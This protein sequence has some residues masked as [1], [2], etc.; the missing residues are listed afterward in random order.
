MKKTDNFF[1]IHNFN[2]VPEVLLSYCESYLIVDASTDKNTENQLKEKGLT[3]I[4]ADNTGHNITTYFEYFAE[5]YERLPEVICLC[6]GN[7]L[8][9][10]LSEEY[11]RRV[12]DNKYFTYLYEDKDS[13]EKFSKIPDADIGNKK[14]GI[15]SISSL[16]TESQYIEENTSWYVESP[17]HP[18]RYFD[19]FDDLLSFIYKDPVIP[20][21]CLFSPGACYIVRREQIK[22]HSPSFYR[23]LN[24][25]MSYELNPNFPSEA[26]MVERMFP[27]IFEAAYEENEWMNDEA[28]FDKKLLER[29]EIIRKK[30][31][32][33]GKRFKRLRK[34]IG[35]HF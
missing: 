8:G 4:H 5:H 30:D 24:K 35:Q 14:A 23:N 2:T 34:L 22:K 12:Y 7:M 18:H 31:E 27:V 32:W 20:R 15:S 17:N 33:N 10:H 6:K 25:I 29:V 9:R 3:Y 26:H 19:N 13:R 1:L 28:A 21:Y 16:V 11:F